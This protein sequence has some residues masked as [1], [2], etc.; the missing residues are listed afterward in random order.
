MA[1]KLRGES[2]KK[3]RTTPEAIMAQF[4]SLHYR[5]TMPTSSISIQFTVI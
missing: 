4:Q 1:K 5:R 2:T 3:E